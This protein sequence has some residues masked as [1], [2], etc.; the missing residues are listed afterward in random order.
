MSSISDDPSQES[1]IETRESD[2][3]RSHGR[4]HRGIADQLRALLSTQQTCDDL[5]ELA[6]QPE[7]EQQLA[8]RS[9]HRKISETFSG[10]L[11]DVAARTGDE[12]LHQ[13]LTSLSNTAQDALRQ[14]DAHDSTNHGAHNNLQGTEQFEG[15]TYLMRTCPGIKP[16]T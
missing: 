12:Q 3:I 2:S 10:I 8:D 5:K 1:I 11:D 9:D 15:V 6:S 16:F 7:L 13:A 4:G 14:T